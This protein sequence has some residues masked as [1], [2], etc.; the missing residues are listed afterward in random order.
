MLAA[1]RVSTQPSFSV[2]VVQPSLRLR[3]RISSQRC[4]IRRTMAVIRRRV[5]ILP[6]G[7]ARAS[8]PSTASASTKSPPATSRRSWM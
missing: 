7:W 5:R 3:S 2:R 4:G 1:S 6:S 8:A